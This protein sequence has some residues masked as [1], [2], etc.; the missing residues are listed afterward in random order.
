[1]GSKIRYSVKPDQIHVLASCIF[2][3]IWH[4]ILLFFY[5]PCSQNIAFCSQPV[6]YDPL[7]GFYS[8]SLY[9]LQ[10]YPASKTLSLFQGVLLQLQINTVGM[11]GLCIFKMLMHVD[12][13]LLKHFAAF[14][15]WPSIQ[16]KICTGMK[17]TSIIWA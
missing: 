14:K 16:I 10:F 4:S 2:F 12:K 1:M 15:L 9:F 3:K 8:N 6:E 5:H 13:I 7:V 11:S 17:Y